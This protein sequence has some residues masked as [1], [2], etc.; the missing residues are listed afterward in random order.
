MSSQK[1]KWKKLGRKQRE[2]AELREE[3]SKLKQSLDEAV[4]STRPKPGT[5][6]KTADS[7]LRKLIRDLQ[8][9]LAIAEQ[10]TA[11]TQRRELVQEGAYENLPRTGVYEELRFDPTK[12]DVCAKLQPTKHTGCII[13]THQ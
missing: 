8:D 5:T 1:F 2:I 3:N 6:S 4:R 9:R 13:V 10:V 7:E 12:V 11:A